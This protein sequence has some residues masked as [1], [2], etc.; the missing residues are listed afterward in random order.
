MLAVKL[1]LPPLPLFVDASMVLDEFIVKLRPA[2]IV[3]VPPL[4]EVEPPVAWSE[5]TII[6]PVAPLAVRV[7]VPPLPFA[8]ALADI[9]CEPLVI[10]ILDPVILI[11]PPLYAPLPPALAENAE[12]P[13]ASVI[14]PGLDPPAFTVIVPPIPLV[15]LAVRLLAEPIDMPPLLL[16]HALCLLSLLFRTIT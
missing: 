4:P 11:A 1:T 2:E 10:L 16:V 12:P 6:S 14:A 9:V 7:I 8:A 3:I 5:S 13:P 15:A